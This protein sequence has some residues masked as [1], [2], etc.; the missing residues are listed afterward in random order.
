MDKQQT[1]RFHYTS[2]R[3]PHWESL[4]SSEGYKDGRLSVGFHAAHKPLE[5]VIQISIMLNR[6]YW[7]GANHI[8]KS[9]LCRWVQSAH[10][11]NP[12]VWKTVTCWIAPETMSE[13]GHTLQ[14]K[15]SKVS[16]KGFNSS[17]PTEVLFFGRCLFDVPSIS[18]KSGEVTG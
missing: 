1:K 12:A 11:C 6:C 14:E 8:G 4:Q 17:A 5:K 7:C 10:G 3:F 18:L 13:K 15:M 9:M 2:D 16:R